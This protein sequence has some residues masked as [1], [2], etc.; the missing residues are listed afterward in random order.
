M[1]V[2][3]LICPA[4][5]HADAID[6]DPRPLRDSDLLSAWLF[7]LLGVISTMAD[8]NARLRCGRCGRRFRRP[9]GVWTAPAAV[10]IAA[11]LFGWGAAAAAEG[12]PGLEV[13]MEPVVKLVVEHPV[14]AVVLAATCCG[15]LLIGLAERSVR[16]GLAE[17]RSRRLRA[18]RARL[19]EELASSRGG[20]D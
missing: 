4:C 19:R 11:A 2:R 5:E 14:G 16:A 15:V 7:G 1:G 20:A 6:R 3:G 9:T 12:T 13:R 18:E 8:R 10:V 17:A